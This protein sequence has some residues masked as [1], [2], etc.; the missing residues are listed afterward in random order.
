MGPQIFSSSFSRLDAA[1]IRGAFVWPGKKK[2]LKMLG[3]D[4]QAHYRQKQNF[5]EQE[6]CDLCGHTLYF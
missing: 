3:R 4:R 1:M 6:A 2:G 5:Q